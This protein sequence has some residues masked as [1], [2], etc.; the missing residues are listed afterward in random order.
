MG[1][2]AAAADLR[3][4]YHLDAHAGQQA[5]GGL[6]D[7]RGERALGAAGEQGH[8]GAPDADGAVL[9]AGA[10]WCRWAAG[11][12]GEL[13]HGAHALRQ[14]ALAGDQPGKWPAETG[15]HPSRARNSVGLG[16]TRARTWR[17]YVR[18]RGA[19]SFSM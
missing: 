16:R 11:W 7:G 10:A 6:V 3:R 18:A 17:K 1:E 15:S 5:Y 12:R 2:R 8:A 9:F 4:D 14:Q 13:Q 19:Q